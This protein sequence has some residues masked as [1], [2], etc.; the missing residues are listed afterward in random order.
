MERTSY[1]AMKQHL[2][3]LTADIRE[4]PEISGETKGE[5]YD[6]LWPF[7]LKLEELKEE[8]Q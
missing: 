6:L 4:A 2:A 1:E 5:M 7:R 3:E 8:P